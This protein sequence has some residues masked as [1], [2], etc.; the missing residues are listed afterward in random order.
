M[1]KRGYASQPH[2]PPSLVQDVCAS[3]VGG[4]LTAS[5][6]HSRTPSLVKQRDLVFP[7]SSNWSLVRR[8]QV[9]SGVL[10]P[11]LIFATT[12]TEIAT[13][14]CP[15]GSFNDDWPL[16]LKGEANRIDLQLSLIVDFADIKKVV[17][18]YNTEKNLNVDSIRSVW[19]SIYHSWMV[20]DILDI[21]RTENISLGSTHRA[22]LPNP[23]RSEV[24][25]KYAMVHSHHTLF[26]PI[27]S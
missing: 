8:S 24:R 4:P 22:G 1:R 26:H 12:P 18:E 3:L 14:M 16:Y 15:D 11:F 20:T 13:D 25:A 27:Q 5:N 7:S 9:I 6:N 21:A 17:E 19:L 2:L 23:M 10:L